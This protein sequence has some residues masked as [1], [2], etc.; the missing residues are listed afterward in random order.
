MVFVLQTVLKTGY[1]ASKWFSV[2]K[3]CLIIRNVDTAKS[4]VIDYFLFDAYKV[5]FIRVIFLLPSLN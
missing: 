5:R 2:K 1:Q 4:N 3:T